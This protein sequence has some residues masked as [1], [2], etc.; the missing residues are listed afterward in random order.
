MKIEELLKNYTS[1]N[2]YK[3]QYKQDFINYYTADYYIRNNRFLKYYLIDLTEPDKYNLSLWKENKSFLEFEAQLLEDEFFNSIGDSRYNI[4]LIFIIPDNAAVG[5][6]VDIQNDFRFARK[7]LL[8]ESEATNFFVNLFK[9]VRKSDEKDLTISGIKQ[10]ELRKQLQQCATESLEVFK[11]EMGVSFFVGATYKK[12]RV[13]EIISRDLLQLLN[14]C[15]YIYDERSKNKSKRQKFVKDKQNLGDCYIKGIPSLTLKNFRRFQK[16]CEIPFKKVN[17][18]FGDN[19]VGK[20]SILDAIELAITGYNINS[21]NSYDDNTLIEVTCLNMN[22]EKISLNYGNNNVSLCN[23][24]YGVR[25]ESKKEFNEFFNQYNYF[26]TSWASAF[27]IEK[28]ERV[29]IRQLQKFLGLDDLGEYEKNIRKLYEKLLDQAK[30]NGKYLGKPKRLVASRSIN[31][32]IQ[33]EKNIIV[34]DSVMKEC[35]DNLYKLKNEIELVTWGSVISEHITNIEEIFKLLICSDEYSSLQ[36]QEDEIVAIRCCDGE[37]VKMSKM[38]TGQKVCLA[39]AF[40]FALFLSN[41]TAPNV[42]MLDEPVA[43]LDD[44]HMLNLLDLLR[45]FALADTQI[46]FTTAN[47]NVAN[48]FRRK[49]SYL[50]DDFGFYRIMD[51]EDHYEVNY[52]QYSM[53]QDEP[54]FVDRIC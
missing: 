54:V 37:K 42:I 25:T 24:W 36:V 19:G 6:F 50:E 12:K 18:L 49:F 27:A 11:K 28:E 41:E 45:R 7:I 31:N 10:K 47:P 46:F 17:L 8:R 13:E 38:S 53:K 15:M 3:I 33:I 35:N 21:K 40:M 20:T 48:L 32:T 5:I 9:L 34:N 39:L 51:K 23:Q 43:H 30:D 26:D 4:Y 2:K 16:Q 1:I 44:L 52:E 29:N 22:N 14:S